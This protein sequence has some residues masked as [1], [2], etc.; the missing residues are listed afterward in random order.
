MK[1][2]PRALPERFAKLGI[3]T[4][5]FILIVSGFYLIGYIPLSPREALILG[6]GHVLGAFF[7]E[8][9]DHLII[10]N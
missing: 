8:H 6:F 2:H 5:L 7:A 4:A 10:F 9:D 3:T 1:F